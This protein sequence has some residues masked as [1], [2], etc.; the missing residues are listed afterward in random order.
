MPERAPQSRARLREFEVVVRRQGC[1]GRLWEGEQRF[2]ANGT[3]LVSGEAGN[4]KLAGAAAVACP[5]NATRNF[6]SRS[7]TAV[8]QAPSAAVVRPAPLPGRARVG[9]YQLRSSRLS[10]KL[11]LLQHATTIV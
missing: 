10:G 6:G 7:G 9:P 4:W 1:R 5:E 11:M 8:E 3:G 2:G